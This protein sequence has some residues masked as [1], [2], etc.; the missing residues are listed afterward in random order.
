MLSLVSTPLILGSQSPRRKQLLAYLDIPFQVI[1]KP[2]NEEE[3]EINFADKSLAIHLAEKKMDAFR[4]LTQE[5][6]ILTADTIVYLPKER[7]VLGKPKGPEEAKRHLRV[8]SGTTHEVITGICLQYQEKRVTAEEITRVTFYPL[9]NEE[10]DYYVTHYSPYD[11]AGG[12]GIQEW[13]G[14]IGIQRIE[15]DFYNVIGLPLHLVY[16]L[17]KAHFTS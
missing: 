5:H 6:I 13:I 3:E 12:Y 10:I 7:R 17:L 8:L 2:I 15:G 11:K 16:A 9:S 4:T 1:V 14:A